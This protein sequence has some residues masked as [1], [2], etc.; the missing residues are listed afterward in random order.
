MSK[1][2][3]YLIRTF[4]AMA[5]LFFYLTAVEL[6]LPSSRKADRLPYFSVCAAIDYEQGAC[7]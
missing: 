5:M 3:R 4:A 7:L 2:I 1:P 6:A